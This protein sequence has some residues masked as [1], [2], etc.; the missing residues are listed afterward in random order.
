MWYVV[1]AD[2]GATLISGFSKQITP[3]EYKE[4]VHNGTFDEVLQTCAIGRVMCSMYLLAVYMVLG[5]VPLW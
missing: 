5:Q 3:K 4:R 1:S 2:E